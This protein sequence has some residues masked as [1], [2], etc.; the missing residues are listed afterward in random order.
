MQR[1]HRE[2]RSTS[3]SC[4]ADEN[5]RSLA[6][7]QA[8][9]EAHDNI[10]NHHDDDRAPGTPVVARLRGQISRE[11]ASEIDKLFAASLPPG[12]RKAT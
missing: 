4:K 1:V 2:C 3:A 8:H 9:N 12:V 6:E 7:R 5:K 10:M 11:L